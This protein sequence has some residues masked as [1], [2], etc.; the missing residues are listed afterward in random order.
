MTILLVLLLISV[1]LHVAI[2]KYIPC[3]MISLYSH[4]KEQDFMT[5][6]FL[7][8]FTFLLYNARRNKCQFH[9]LPTTTAQ[10][11]RNKA[12]KYTVLEVIKLNC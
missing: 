1:P 3:V 6:I 2:Q 12:R 8:I 11:Q 5:R 9:L 7:V 4:K 10:R